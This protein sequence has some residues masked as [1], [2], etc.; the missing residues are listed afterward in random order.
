MYVSILV[1]DFCPLKTEMTRFSIEFL[2]CK[3][4]IF[5]SALKQGKESTHPVFRR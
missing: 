2:D 5:K 3:V 1:Q 4:S